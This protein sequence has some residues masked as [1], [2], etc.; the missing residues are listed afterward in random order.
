MCVLLNDYSRQAL[1]LETRTAVCTA[2]AGL[3]WCLVCMGS[4]QS[5]GCWAGDRMPPVSENSVPT[6]CPGKLLSSM[7]RGT[8]TVRMIRV[9]RWSGKASTWDLHV[10]EHE[11]EM[12]GMK[13]QFDSPELCQLVFPSH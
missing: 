4:A 6:A 5:F 1:V 7:V 13:E 12:L 3:G 2:R 11:L 10:S 9:L 8:I